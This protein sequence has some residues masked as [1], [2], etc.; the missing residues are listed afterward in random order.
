MPHRR[1]LSSCLLLLGVIVLTGGCN[2]STT[3]SSPPPNPQVGQGQPDTGPYAEGRKVFAGSG[4][5]RC[6]TAGGTQTAGPKGKMGG[7]D[8]GKVGSDPEHT[9]EW[10]AAKIRDPQAT[11]PQSRMPKH[12]E[13]KINE[14][15]MK[16]LVEYLAS[17]K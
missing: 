9:T 8:L 6:H 1:S 13:G 5:A 12:D 14:N 11:K 17:L 10:L 15:D 16:S 4:C 2:K 3:A 7:P